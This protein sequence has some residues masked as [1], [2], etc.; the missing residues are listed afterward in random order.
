MDGLTKDSQ[1][2]VNVFAYPIHFGNN[3]TFEYFVTHDEPNLFT[4]PFESLW[5]KLVA[6]AVFS[7]GL[8]ASC[9]QYSFVYY[10]FNGLAASFRT[11]VN[12][13]VS[14]SYFL[15]STSFK[16][17]CSTSIRATSNQERLVNTVTNLSVGLLSNNHLRH[18]F[19]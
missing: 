2:K 15:V 10:E 14:W 9:I 16:T 6:T 7:L 17:L 4:E 19:V 1:V 12:Q 18:G 13:L 3:E 8:I 5:I 11:V